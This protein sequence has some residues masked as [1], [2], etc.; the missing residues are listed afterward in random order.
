[1]KRM[2]IAVAIALVPL[3]VTVAPALAATNGGSSTAQATDT[4]ERPRI[5][6]VFGPWKYCI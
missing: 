4:A 1:M 5:C 2:L 3:T 6:F